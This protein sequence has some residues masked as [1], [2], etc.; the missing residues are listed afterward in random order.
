MMAAHHER[1]FDQ[2]SDSD[3][4]PST[5]LPLPAL[6]AMMLAGSGAGFN[7]PGTGQIRAQPL[8]P[9]TSRHGKLQRVGEQVMNENTEVSRST[10]I[11][12][13]TRLHRRAS[14][15]LLGSLCA[16][17]SLFGN[18]QF[19]AAL[20]S[21]SASVGGTRAGSIYG[22]G[23]ELPLELSALL[24]GGVVGSGAPSA[25]NAL[26]SVQDTGFDVPD[27]RKTVDVI[28]DYKSRLPPALPVDS[29]PSRDAEDK[30]FLDTLP[31][32]FCDDKNHQLNPRCALY[33]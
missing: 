8:L 2:A 14:L 24:Q 19:C 15:N 18:P 4:A 23:P 31:P 12:R 11:T 13:G 10:G 20:M 22:I 30:D 1:A 26:R 6:A 5:S 16:L 25:D 29:Q 21:A 3:V 27:G 28:Q 32:G 17:T 9:S 7:V 33:G